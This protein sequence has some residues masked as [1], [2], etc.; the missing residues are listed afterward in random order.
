M[1]NL[2]YHR[3]LNITAKPYLPD[4]KQTSCDDLLD[5]LRLSLKGTIE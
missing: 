2:S 4:K 1:D 5:A 3:T